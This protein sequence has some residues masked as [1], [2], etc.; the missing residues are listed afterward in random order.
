[1]PFLLWWGSPNALLLCRDG[2]R[3][4]DLQGEDAALKPSQHWRLV[5]RV[6]RAQQLQSGK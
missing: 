1:M 6:P 3:D 5:L 2:S 4:R